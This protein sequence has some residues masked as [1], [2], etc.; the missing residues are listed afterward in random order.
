M[1]HD[2]KPCG[3]PGTP[4]A[5]QGLSDWPATAGGPEAFWTPQDP[6]RQRVLPEKLQAPVLKQAFA[7]PACTRTSHTRNYLLVLHKVND[8]PLNVCGTN[9]SHL[10]WD[11][12]GAVV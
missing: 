7:M 8:L 11:N 5:Y 9:A 2:R 6:E 1:E 3:L 12:W 10:L 4:S